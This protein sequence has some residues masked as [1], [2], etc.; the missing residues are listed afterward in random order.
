MPSPSV[1][2][3][4]KTIPMI[5]LDDVSFIKT[6]I[7]Q[8]YV[9]YQ[10]VPRPYGKPIEEIEALGKMLFPFSN[11]SFELAVCVYDWT[12]GSF[13]R[14]VL[15]KIFEY[16]GIAKTPFPI[17]LGSI[18][19]QIYTS[20]WGTYNPRDKDYM[21]SFMMKPAESLADV[22]IQLGNVATK[23]HKLSDIQNRL[24]SAAVQSLPRTSVIS[25]PQLY[26]GQLD[27]RQLGLDHFGIEFL[28]CHLNKGPVDEPLS[29]PFATF[30]ES[31]VTTGKT[32]T[33][34]AV[35]SATD[36]MDMAMKYSNGILL[37]FNP[38]Q[39][40][41]VWD[42]VTFITPLSANEALM[43]YAF[44]PRT[45]FEVQSVHCAKI[46]TKEVVV[47]TLQ[48]LHTGSGAQVAKIDCR[49]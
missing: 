39:G 42:G 26:S 35:W 12:T 24:L 2:G 10:N 41:L 14:S 5:L 7:G 43:E 3:R 34:K 38:P 23:L 1:S 20:D 30:M 40:S 28:E 15:F 37:I 46:M 33:T 13:A 44:L 48:Q 22:L 49:E 25:R 4:L 17:D 6:M 11:H 8:K 27:M 47:I 16:T 21:N 18:A 19:K 9:P 45:Q 36:T 29:I 32:L 31:H